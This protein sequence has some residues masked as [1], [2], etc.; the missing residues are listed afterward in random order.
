MS[1]FQWIEGLIAVNAVLRGKSREVAEVLVDDARRDGRIARLEAAAR[2]AGADV[3]RVPS[4]ELARF[5]G[6]ENHAGVIALVGPRVLAILDALLP[7]SGPAAVVMLDGVEDPYNF[8]QA[9]RAFY[10]AGLSGLVV[11][12]RNWLSA[13]AVVARASAGASELLP[14]AVAETAE[15]AAAFFRAR[16]LVVA[17]AAQE[18]SISLYEA[19]LRAPIFLV[20]GG[21]K[22]GITR[23]FLRAADLRLHIPYG[24]EVDY[25]LGT[26]TA[27]AAF[28]FEIMRQRM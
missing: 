5:A 23:S 22:R 24:R 12:P 8:G 4:A 11:R 2:E 26:A 3:R 7:E 19:D 10:A 21:E 15:D 17:C 6:D 16:G 28:A 9:V 13:A 18:E 1:D 14:V 27:S 20:I 25:S